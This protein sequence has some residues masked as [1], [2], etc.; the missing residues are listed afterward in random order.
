MVLV[1]VEAR[2][3]SQIRHHNMELLEA[4][5]FPMVME[6]VLAFRTTLRIL[7]EPSDP[8]SEGI[9]GGDSVLRVGMILSP[10]P[11]II[12]HCTCGG[13]ISPSTRTKGVGMA[14]V[15]GQIRDG[16]LAFPAVGGSGRK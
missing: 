13:Q 10:M 14:E 16:M 4:D 1:R 3:R 11:E 2:N 15:M 12:A 7:P 5:T 6:V 8:G 9:E